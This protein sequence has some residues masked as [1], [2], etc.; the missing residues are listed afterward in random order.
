MPPKLSPSY[1]IILRLEF[2]DVPG[3]LGRIT[4]AI[5]KAGGTIDAVDIVRVSGERR[6][7]D[8]SVNCASAEH[9]DA[10]VKTVAAIPRLKVVDVSDRTF[11]LHRRGKISIESKLPLTSRDALAMVYTPG[12]ARVSQAIHENPDQA[13]ALTMKGRTV[14]IVTDGTAVLGLGNI[15][16]RAALPVMEGKAMLFK[17]FGAVDAFPI[18]LDTTDVDEIIAIVKA[19][20]PGFGGVN[21]EDIAAPRCFEIEERLERELDIPVF[22]DDQHG[23]AIV[24]LAALLNTLK[25]VGKEMRSIRVVVSGVGAAGVATARLLKRA[26]CKRIIGC[27]TA[28]AVFKGRKEHMNPAKL[29]FAKNTNPERESGSLKKVLRGADVFIGVSAPGILKRNDVKTMAKDAVVFALANPAPE[30]T[31]EEA[32]RS[33]RI[34]AT[35]RSDYPNQI[36]NVLCFPGLFRGALDCRA[37]NITTPMKMAAA[38]AIARTIAPEELNENHIIPSVFDKRVAP[39]VAK[40]VARAARARQ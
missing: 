15:G 35:G 12:V 20:A 9:A 19:I 34:I 22:H 7:R 11:L 38:K 31:P 40:A 18:C 6:T 2:P 1:S 27:D 17:E 13:Y 21:L 23:T 30:I 5:G 28:G 16:P 37:R 14:A 36:N 25:I 8:I 3:F 32:G 4:T 10:L 33:V 24:V 39:A 26:G 29:W